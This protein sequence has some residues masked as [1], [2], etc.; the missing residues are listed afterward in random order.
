M[1]TFPKAQDAVTNF[2]APTQYATR[3]QILIRGLP[4]LLFKDLEECSNAIPGLE[5]FWEEIVCRVKTFVIKM[6]CMPLSQILL[7]L[8]DIICSVIAAQSIANIVK[9]SLGPLGLDKMLVDN[10]GVLP[11]VL[12]SALLLIHSTL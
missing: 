12:S 9:S 11:T 6:V 2:Q 4:F 3:F 10:I 7:E 1:G 8:T 5:L